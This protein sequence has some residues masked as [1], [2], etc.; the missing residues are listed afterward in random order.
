MVDQ[1]A[2]NR[3]K[4]L[5]SGRGANGEQ[6]DH[7]LLDAHV[8]QE[9]PEQE[10]L[11]VRRQLL[12]KLSHTLAITRDPGLCFSAKHRVDSTVK[13]TLQSI[14]SNNSSFLCHV[15]LLGPS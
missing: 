7:R 15:L 14:A 8:S 9:S 6:A 12:L 3:C 11:I 13:W 5:N 4:G 10:S 2:D 1:F